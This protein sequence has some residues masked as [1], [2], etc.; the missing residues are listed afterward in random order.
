MLVPTALYCSARYGTAAVR[1]MIATSAARAGLLPNR[2]EMKS[3]IE[4]VLCA[5]A[6]ATS[7]CRK[8]VAKTN[9]STGPR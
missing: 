1:A 7:R 8:G 9:T 3:A 5:R 4:V 6:I 2:A